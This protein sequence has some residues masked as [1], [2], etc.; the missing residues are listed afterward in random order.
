MTEMIFSF[1]PRFQKKKKYFD[2]YKRN[3]LFEKDTKAKKE[4]Q[5]TKL[6]SDEKSSKKRF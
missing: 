4:D 5:G 6:F 2:F 1:D 3:C